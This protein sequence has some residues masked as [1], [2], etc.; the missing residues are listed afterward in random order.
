MRDCARFLFN[1]HNPFYSAQCRLGHGRFA[2][3]EQSLGA[4]CRWAWWL[5]QWLGL[6]S[7]AS[8][9]LP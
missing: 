1:N 9:L 5:A 2:R 3:G 8:S 6:Y 4:D 7:T